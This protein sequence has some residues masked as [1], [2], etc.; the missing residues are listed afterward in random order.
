MLFVC[1][2]M[3]TLAF[4]FS[5]PLQD[6]SGGE[7]ELNDAVRKSKDYTESKVSQTEAHTS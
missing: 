1:L 2:S 3:R 6:R 5:L 4:V 7:E